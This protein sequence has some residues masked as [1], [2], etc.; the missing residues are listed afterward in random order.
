MKHTLS[1]YYSVLLFIDSIK[2]VEMANQMKE[3]IKPIHNHVFAKLG[4][5]ESKATEDQL[6]EYITRLELP[7]EKEVNEKECGR[8]LGEYV[9]ITREYLGG[10]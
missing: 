7:K 9:T 8:L 6:I 2:I 3:E 10:T 4:S 1:A 5:F